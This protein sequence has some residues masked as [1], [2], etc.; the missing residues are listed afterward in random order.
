[1]RKLLFVFLMFLLTSITSYKAALSFQ[2]SM[3]IKSKKTTLK[4]KL[5]HADD[6]HVHIEKMQQACF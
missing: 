6:I 2:T 5:H 4:N 3:Y 1:M